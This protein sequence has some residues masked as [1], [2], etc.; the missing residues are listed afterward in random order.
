MPYAQIAVNSTRGAERA[1]GCKGELGGG[2]VWSRVRV[3]TRVSAR[4]SWGE[5]N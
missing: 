3:S 5:L 2:E 4:V 1:Q